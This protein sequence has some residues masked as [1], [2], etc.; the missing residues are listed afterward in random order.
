MVTLDTLQKDQRT[1]ILRL[2]EKRGAR[3]IRIF[4]SVARG[5]RCEWSD[6]DLLVEF[7]EGRTLFDLIGLRLD[8]KDLLGTGVDIVTPKSLRY[9]RDRVVAEARAL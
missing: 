5:E 8:L 1:E 9:L 3:T 6:V 2:G 7:E 4:G